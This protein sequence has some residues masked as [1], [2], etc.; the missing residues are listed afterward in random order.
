MISNHLVDEAAQLAAYFLLEELAGA[1]RVVL[2]CC[3]GDVVYV[4]D[5]CLYGPDLYL[6]R[7]CLEYDAAPVYDL[8]VLPVGQFIVKDYHW[9]A[10]GAARLYSRIIVLE[11]DCLMG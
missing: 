8:H 10:L 6:V 11:H 9:I 5:Q 7:E 2:V 3:Y 4:E 1:D